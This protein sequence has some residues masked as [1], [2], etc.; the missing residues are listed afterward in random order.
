MREIGLT[1]KW[2]KRFFSALQ[3][4][5]GWFE[6]QFQFYTLLLY[7]VKKGIDFHMLELLHCTP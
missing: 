6:K 4:V 2:E 7:I 3:A 5:S 1:A